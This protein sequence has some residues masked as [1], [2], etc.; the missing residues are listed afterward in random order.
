MTCTN[1]VSWLKCGLKDWII[2]REK[3]YK[4]KRFKRD[5]LGNEEA[6]VYLFYEN[7]DAA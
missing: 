6:S 5:V 2:E 7:L 3:G 4:K 1:D